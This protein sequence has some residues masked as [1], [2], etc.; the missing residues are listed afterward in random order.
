MSYFI[1]GARG[2]GPGKT[3]SAGQ[4]HTLDVHAESPEIGVSV[5]LYHSVEDK[6]DKVLITLSGGVS[7]APVILGAFTRRD[8]EKIRAGEMELI[9]TPLSRPED[10]NISEQGDNH[11]YLDTRTQ[12]AQ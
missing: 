8:Y 7:G 6:E 5:S 11:E 9:K 2:F 4:Y 3:V 1:G 12:P 10:F